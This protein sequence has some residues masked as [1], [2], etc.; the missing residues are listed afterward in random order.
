VQV[1]PTGIDIRNGLQMSCIS[2]ALCIDACDNI[3]DNLGWERGLIR[4]ASQNEMQG[5]RTRL[6]KLKNISY[7][8]AL[9]AASAALVWSIVNKEPV[10]VSVS[11]VRNPMYVMLSDGRLQ[12]S[13][14]L[15][16]ANKTEYPMAV[17]IQLHGLDQAQ[18]QLGRLHD[19]K[20]EPLSSLNLFIKVRLKPE[21]SHGVQLPFDFVIDAIFNDQTVTYTKQALFTLPGGAP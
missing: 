14:E 11:Q 15:S 7:A 5:K 3:M 16:I 8:I 21:H 1:C 13:Y 9:L 2:C 17:R 20:I 6:F 12:N 4:Y 18:V 10:S 19:V